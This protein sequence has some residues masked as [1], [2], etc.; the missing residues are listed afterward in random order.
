I[1]RFGTRICMTIFAFGWSFANVASGLSHNFSQLAASRALLGAAE[2]GVFP[3]IQRA[4]LNW[5]PVERRALA[6]GIVMPA[7]NLGAILAPPLVALMTA[8]I[9]WRAAFV[10]PGV[11]GIAIAI[12]WW[13]VDTKPAPRDEAS[14]DTASRERAMN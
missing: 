13:L 1:E 4:I 5:V 11:I 8:G 10:I 2:P 6:I 3:I 7:G 9:G 14:S 12:L